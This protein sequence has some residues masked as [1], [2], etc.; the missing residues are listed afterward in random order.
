MI[1]LGAILVFRI[2]DGQ[3]EQALIA[4]AIALGVG[5]LLGAVNGFGITLLG[6]PPLVMTLGMAGVV[7][8]LILVIT[9]GRVEGE[10]APA[11]TGLVSFWGAPCGWS[12]S[13]PPT[14]GGSSPWAPI[15]SPQ[16]SLG[17][18]YHRFWC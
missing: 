13:A 10:A 18:E 2:G 14:A 7:Q 12:C 8:G 9:G 11:L 3:N 17:Y 1:T 4:L 5:L 16:S 15:A 6:I